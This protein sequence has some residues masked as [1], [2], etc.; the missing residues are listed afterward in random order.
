MRIRHRLERLERRLPGPPPPTPDQL[1]RQQR[2]IQITKRFTRLLRQAE[3]L[4]NEVENQLVAEAL[5]AYV[6]H[7]DGALKHWLWNLREGCCR[8]PEL[9]AEAMRQVLLNLFHPDS[10]DPKV[11]N[12][13]GLECARYNYHV[14]SRHYDPPDKERWAELARQYSWPRSFENCPGCG[15]SNRDISWPHQTEGVDHPWKTLDGWM[16]W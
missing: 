9:S 10:G 16:G 4:L 8:L 7:Q 13:C 15:G 5:E 12:Q 6:S 1:R 3:P 14:M 11:C 2:W